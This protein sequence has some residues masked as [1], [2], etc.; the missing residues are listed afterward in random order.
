M[1][2]KNC[3]YRVE[4]CCRLSGDIVADFLVSNFKGSVSGVEE[5]K[6]EDYYRPACKEH[7]Y[8]KLIEMIRRS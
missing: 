2:C 1:N 3:V 7:T 5:E 6:N 8:L 4:R